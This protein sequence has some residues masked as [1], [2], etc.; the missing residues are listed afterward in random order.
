MITYSIL[1]ALLSCL[2]YLGF[3]YDKMET[4]LDQT[5]FQLESK[6]HVIQSIGI[7][8]AFLN[9]KN[10][11]LQANLDNIHIKQYQESQQTIVFFDKVS[12]TITDS[13]NLVKVGNL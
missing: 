11:E 6:D 12:Q 1:V 2:I 7:E 10:A 9:R 4:E 13:D 5:L 3:K 8:N